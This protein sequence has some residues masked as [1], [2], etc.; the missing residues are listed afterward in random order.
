M[1]T[2]LILIELHCRRP[3]YKYVTSGQYEDGNDAFHVCITGSDF[4]QCMQERLEV[5]IVRV[6][7][8]KWRI[9]AA[10]AALR[11]KGK[12]TCMIPRMLT[13]T[14]LHDLYIQLLE[15]QMM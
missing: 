5:Y 15:L 12:I 6:R 8:R 3:D 11:R 13:C 10:A 9:A 4:A 7:A 2:C 1:D 14:Q